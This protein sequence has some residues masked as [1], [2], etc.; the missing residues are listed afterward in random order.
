MSK[1]AGGGWEKDLYGFDKAALSDFSV[2]FGTE[3]FTKD[4]IGIR[5]PEGGYE[6]DVWFDA[7]LTDGASPNTWMVLY[8]GSGGGIAFGLGTGGNPDY[9]ASRSAVFEQIDP[10]NSRWALSNQMNVSVSAIPAPVP[11]PAAL[12]LLLSALGFFG[13]MGWRRKRTAAA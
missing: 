10:F 7:P 8:N 1:T 11:I 6:A 12:P 4:D 2:T 5:I 3:T 13:F 9:L